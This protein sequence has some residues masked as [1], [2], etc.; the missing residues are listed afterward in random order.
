MSNE[1]EECQGEKNKK[2]NLSE[3]NV[4]SLYHSN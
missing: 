2:K 1:T 3:R 4:L